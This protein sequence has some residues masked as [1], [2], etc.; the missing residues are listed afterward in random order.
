MDG[1]NKIKELARTG[2]KMINPLKEARLDNVMPD[3]SVISVRWDSPTYDL[4]MANVK[5]KA[6]IM[7]DKTR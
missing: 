5:L 4:E 6:Q 1:S 3:G 7:Y 2:F